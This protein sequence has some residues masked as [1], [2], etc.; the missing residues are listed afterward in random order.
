MTAN[1]TPD[2]T[3]TGDVEQT[4]RNRTMNYASGEAPKIND[5]VARIASHQWTNEALRPVGNTRIVSYVG[6][7]GTYIWFNGE[8]VS[9]LSSLFNLVCRNG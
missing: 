4:K 1:Y 9:W 6:V 5:T 2:F 8:S 3:R 7:D